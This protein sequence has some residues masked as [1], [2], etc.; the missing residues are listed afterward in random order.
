MFITNLLSETLKYNSALRGR[1]I[2]PPQVPV[3]YCLSK[4]ELSQVLKFFGASNLQVTYEDE[5]A[6]ETEPVEQEHVEE[7][8]G[9]AEEKC[10]EGHPQTIEETLTEKDGPKEGET[11]TEVQQN[12][13]HRKATTTP[14]SKKK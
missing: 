4:K 8:V 5:T 2:F 7:I 9:E 6:V 11:V 10:V 14:K 12:L 3:G 1:L 13:T